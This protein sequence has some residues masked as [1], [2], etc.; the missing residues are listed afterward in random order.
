M[1]QHLGSRQLSIISQTAAPH[2]DSIATAM[3]SMRSIKL[4]FA[5]NFVCAFARGLAVSTRRTQTMAAV[6]VRW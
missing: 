6:L 1:G 4:S 2:D 5:K 3:M